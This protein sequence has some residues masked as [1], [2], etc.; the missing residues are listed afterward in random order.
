MGIVLGL[1]YRTFVKAST[2]PKLLSH[3]LEIE[4]LLWIFGKRQNFTLASLF[5][6][7]AGDSRIL[8][9]NSIHEFY[10][11]SP[12][13]DSHTLL[14]FGWVVCVFPLIHLRTKES[15][16][17]QEKWLTSGKWVT[18]Y[19]LAEL[20]G[21]YQHIISIAAGKIQTFLG[22]NPKCSPSDWMYMLPLP[23]RSSTS[24]ECTLHQRQKNV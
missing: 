9:I 11:P 8:I 5:S 14:P 2:K 13:K 15:K 21:L 24:I 22:R 16:D 23:E 19:M 6:F 10:F 17:Q 1:H 3:E 4:N 20:Q 12:E 7:W 18:L